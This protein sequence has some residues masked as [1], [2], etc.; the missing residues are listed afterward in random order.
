MSS[1]VL[2]CAKNSIMLYM[3]A[4]HVLSSTQTSSKLIR[5]TAC[6]YHVRTPGKKAR[7]ILQWAKGGGSWQ[8]TRWQRRVRDIARMAPSASSASPCCISKASTAIPARTKKV[9]SPL[10]VSMAKTQSTHHAGVSL[11]A[12]AV[13]GDKP[14]GHFWT[15]SI[16]ERCTSL[17]ER[18]RIAPHRSFVPGICKTAKYATC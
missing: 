3:H 17:A 4:L 6:S 5:H 9:R 10:F 1:T 15:A 11:A 12:L 2:A 7:G 8:A 18:A 13:L 16:R 14:V